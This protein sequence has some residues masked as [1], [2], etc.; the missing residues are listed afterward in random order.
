MSHHE[1]KRLWE[2][3]DVSC[4]AAAVAARHTL[5]A[6]WAMP[7]GWEGPAHR[8]TQSQ[9]L[10]GT[11][12]DHLVQPLLRASSSWVLN[13]FQDGD[14]TTSL[15]NL[16]QS[17]T[18]LMVE[19]SYVWTGFPVFQNLCPLLLVLS[20]VTSESDCL[21]HF[22]IM[23]FYTVISLSVRMW[24][25]TLSKPL[26]ESRLVSM[27]WATTWPVWWWCH[28]SLGRSVAPVASLH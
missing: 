10:A 23:Y 25:E 7:K 14:A 9:R 19:V 28:L 15:G 16:C 22:P 11:C 2:W 17:L 24:W 21:L 26:L 27:K 4:A 5:G 12:G 3:P 8:V 13:I 1:G 20:P 18:T 6:S